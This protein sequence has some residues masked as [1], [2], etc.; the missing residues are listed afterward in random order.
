MSPSGN[1]GVK[2]PLKGKGVGKG[3]EVGRVYWRAPDF[4]TAQ[5]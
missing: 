2:T 5:L 1:V 4:S 3:V